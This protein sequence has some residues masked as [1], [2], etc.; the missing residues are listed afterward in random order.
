MA[1]KPRAYRLQDA[2][3][4]TIDADHYLGFS[5]DER[6]FGPA[7][8]ILKQLG[9]SR[10]ELLTNNPHKIDFMRRGGLDV[11]NRVALLAPVNPFNARYVQTKHERAAHFTQASSA[12]AARDPASVMRVAAEAA[13]A[14]PPR[15]AA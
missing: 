12:H 13:D 3:L 8:A 11:V 4:D 9:I 15:P 5:A 7:V 10:I 14:G 6:D 2:G 1:N